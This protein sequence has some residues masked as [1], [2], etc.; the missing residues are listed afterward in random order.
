MPK[1]SS[2]K[3]ETFDC[4]RCKSYYRGKVVIYDFNDPD[5]LKGVLLNPPLISSLCHGVHPKDP[6]EGK[7]K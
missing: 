3:I 2:E 4:P 1:E 5:F 7:S 6:N